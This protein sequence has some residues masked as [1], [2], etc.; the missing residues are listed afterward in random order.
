MSEKA[1]SPKINTYT[2]AAIGMMAALVFVATKIQIQIPTAIGRTRLHFGN[3]FCLLSGMLLGGVRGGLAAGIGSMFFDFT[4]PAFIDSAPF[5][6]VFK[7]AMGAIC[8]L[9]T[10][11]GGANSRRPVRN[12]IGCLA[13]A[14]S[15]VA[16]SIGKSFVTDYY[17]MRNPLET[18]MTSLAQKGTVSLV[19]AVLAVVAALLLLPA[20]RKAYEMTGYKDK[21]A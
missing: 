1:R 14:F 9:I 7:F 3:V 11:G 4:D 16:L 5:T 8:G 6:L 20:F 12:L 18:V 13:G 10:N 2:I 15:S 19:N 21:M 17:L